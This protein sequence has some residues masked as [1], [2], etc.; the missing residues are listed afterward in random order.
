MGILSQAKIYL[1]VNSKIYKYIVM[2]S[3]SLKEAFDCSIISVFNSANNFK[4]LIEAKLYI[5]III[6]NFMIQLNMLI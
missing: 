6:I 4:H 2:K 1:G 3:S 5:F